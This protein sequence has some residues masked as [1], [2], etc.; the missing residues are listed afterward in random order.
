MTD[1]DSKMNKFTDQE[2]VMPEEKSVGE[3]LM[4]ENDALAAFDPDISEC[5]PLMVIG[6]LGAILFLSAILFFT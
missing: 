3:R 4:A 2:L 1:L 5:P 6:A